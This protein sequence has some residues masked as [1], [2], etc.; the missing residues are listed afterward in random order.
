MSFAPVSLDGIQI[1]GLTQSEPGGVYRRGTVL[2]VNN[3]YNSNQRRLDLGDTKSRSASNTRGLENAASL[4]RRATGVLGATDQA[5]EMQGRSRLTYGLDG[6][7]AVQVGGAVVDATKAKRVIV[8]LGANG[9]NNTRSETVSRRFIPTDV[10][11]LSNQRKFNSLTELSKGNDNYTGS[12]GR[13]LLL[14]NKGNNAV[15][16]GRG[17]DLV[18]MNNRIKR[19]TVELGKGKDTLLVTEKGL[20]RSGRLTI[21]DFNNKSDT[22][23]LES[24]RSKVSGFGTDQLRISASKGGTMRL[25]SNGDTF[26]RSSVEFVG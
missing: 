10:R 2:I 19:S 17:K 16:M 5:V 8:T 7:K 18:V 15:A 21:T 24:N 22:I 1:N 3:D 20:K 14:L 9:V 23:Q 6:S 11:S 26:S 25:V 12:S 13:D 4:R